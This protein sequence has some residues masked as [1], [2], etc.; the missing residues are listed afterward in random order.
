MPV[1]DIKEYLS[2]VM[3]Q[4]SIP[5]DSVILPDIIL[6]TARI[7]AV[8]INE[9]PPREKDDWFYSGTDD[10]GYTRSALSLFGAAGYAF[11]GIVDIINAGIY[12]TTAVKSPKD[13]YVVDTEIMK[14]HMPLFDAELALF[15]N[16]KVI[17]LMGDTAKKV[18]NMLTKAKTKKNVIPS[19]ATYKIRNSEFFWQ[20]IR[21][22]P[23]Y[24]M[25]GGNLLIEKGK[26]DVIAGDIKKMMELCG[27]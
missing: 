17:M 6:D 15:E 5:S 11:G 19:G 24:I 8:M 22:I 21:V 26:C 7:R 23:S 12:I 2:G 10:P 9:V 16:L 1:I 13:G 3:L 25:T 20:G 27:G 18:F 14:L 4:N